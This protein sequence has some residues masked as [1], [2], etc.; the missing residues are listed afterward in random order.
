[1]NEAEITVTARNAGVVAAKR[2]WPRGDVLVA[3]FIADAELYCHS[4][5]TVLLGDS[6]GPTTLNL[7]RA[8]FIDAFVTTVVHQIRM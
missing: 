8:T 6:P 7:F 5:E 3:A 4:A 1:M 2:Y